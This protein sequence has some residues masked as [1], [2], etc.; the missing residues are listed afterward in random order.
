MQGPVEGPK[1]EVGDGQRGKVLEIA[2]EIGKTMA[3][4]MQQGVVTVPRIHIAVASPAKNAITPV[5]G[6][7]RGI[8]SA[9]WMWSRIRPPAR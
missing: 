4:R 3:R 8:A 7:N 5:A 6:L 1:V 2:H 9:P